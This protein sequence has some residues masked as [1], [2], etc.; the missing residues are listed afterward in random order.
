MLTGISAALS[1]RDNISAISKKEAPI[2]RERQSVSS[3]EER[4]STDTICG[5]RSPIQE[6]M[7]LTETTEAVKSVESTMHVR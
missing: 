1:V 2:G 4:K 7:P 3:K 6:T 5:V